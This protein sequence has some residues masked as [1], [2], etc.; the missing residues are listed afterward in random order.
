[1]SKV[2]GFA[3]QKRCPA[4]DCGMVLTL[5][6]DGT[7]PAHGRGFDFCKNVGKTPKDATK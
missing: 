3:Q 1:M 6:S 5:H 4:N 2:T 7:F